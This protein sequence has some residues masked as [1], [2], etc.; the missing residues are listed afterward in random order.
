MP[1]WINQPWQRNLSKTASGKPGA[2]QGVAGRSQIVIFS[3]FA[4]L[5][6][7][8]CMINPYSAE[9]IYVIFA[10]EASW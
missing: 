4:G 5:E 2:V 8:S 6:R 10:S 1:H 7:N 9:P 3:P